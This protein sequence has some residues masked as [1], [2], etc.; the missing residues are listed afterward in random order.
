MGDFQVNMLDKLNSA[1]AGFGSGDSS[2][3]G[4]DE[5]NKYKNVALFATHLQPPA[6]N[7]GSVWGYGTAGG[8]NPTAAA[9]LD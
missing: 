3:G 6:V 8:S 9:N 7:N 2:V 1:V 5:Q 4:I